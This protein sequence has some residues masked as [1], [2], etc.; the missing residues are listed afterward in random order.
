[1]EV[2]DDR[3]DAECKGVNGFRDVHWIGCGD[4]SKE[5]VATL[6]ASRMNILKAILASEAITLMDPRA[7]VAKISQEE[8]GPDARRCATDGRSHYSLC[9]SK[10]GC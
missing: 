6:R 7:R 8:A 3:P 10:Y 1:M 5:R 9:L 4:S 2:E